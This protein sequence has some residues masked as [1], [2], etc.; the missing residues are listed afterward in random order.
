MRKVSQR[1]PKKDK[2][3]EIRREAIRKLKH[4]PRRSQ[5]LNNSLPRK[6]GEKMK[7]MISSKKII[8]ENFLE[9]RNINFQIERGS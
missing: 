4:P 2:E 8:Q 7:G 5:Q 9:S 3:M 1:Q 6:R